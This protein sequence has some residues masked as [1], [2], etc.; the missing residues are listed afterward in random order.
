MKLSP[1]ETKIIEFLSNKN[2]EFYE[3]LAQ[4][5]KDPQK[6]KLKTI[7]KIIS[8]IKKKHKDAEQELPFTCTLT[9]MLATSV[10]TPKADPNKETVSFNGQTLTKILRNSKIETNLSVFETIGAAT[11]S[12][13]DFS[14]HR[15]TRQVLTKSGYHGL[16]ADDFEVFEYLYQNRGR[17]I[18]LEELRDKVCFPKFGSKTPNRWFD[19]IGRRINNCR[20]NIP[21]AKDKLLT[22]KMNNATGYQLSL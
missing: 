17:A 15:N 21:E 13:P 9:S 12:K 7:K 3:H 18:P 22:V 8:D 14:I 10:K 20:R 19:V 1:Q 2:E 5:T 6:T 16:N 11:D 4:F